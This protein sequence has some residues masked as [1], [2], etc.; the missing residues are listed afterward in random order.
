MFWSLL[1]CGCVADSAWSPAVPPC[2][3]RVPSAF[4]P[5]WHF[6]AW[7]QPG[8]VSS[9]VFWCCLL[10]VARLLACTGPST[11]GFWSLLVW[12]I[13]PGMASW[14]RL[15]LFGLSSLHAC[16]RWECWSGGVPGCWSPGGLRL[17]FGGGSSG[18]L[19]C[20]QACAYSPLFS[21]IQLGWSWFVPGCGVRPGLSGAVGF[22]WAVVLLPVLPV[23]LSPGL[24]ALCLLV[25]PCGC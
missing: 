17:C 2:G 15:G 6:G 7:L 4:P 18:L 3:R 23:V 8:R 25:C 9:W 11:V 5:C 22:L 1:V 12:Y 21:V 16:Y 20:I 13:P 10:G 19:C 24:L 14:L